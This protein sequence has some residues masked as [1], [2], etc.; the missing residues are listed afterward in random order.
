MELLKRRTA[1]CQ[2]RGDSGGYEVRIKSD[3]SKSGLTFSCDCPYAAEGNFCKHMVAAA[4]ELTDF[5]DDSD[6][7]DFD[8][9]Y[10][11]PAVYRKPPSPPRRPAGRN[12]QNRL[13]VA[14]ASGP[15]R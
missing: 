13:G 14:L 6:D 15:Q 12:W 10:L 3:S 7:D 11:E 4:L 5:L 1:V 9:D 2:V 8:E